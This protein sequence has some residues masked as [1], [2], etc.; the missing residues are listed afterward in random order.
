MEN[1]SLIS[2][3][4]PVYNVEAFLRQCVDS[5][6]A[7]TYKNLEI[8]LVDD[9]S[10]DQS[11]AICDEYAQRYPNIVAIHKKNGGLSS[12]RNT[13]I[14]AAKGAFLGFVDSDDFVE[15]TM[16]EKLLTA[17]AANDAS[18]ACCGR[19]V[20]DE[21]G[22]PLARRFTRK[23]Q[24]V[25]TML[26]AAQEILSLG[27]ID[28]AVWDKLFRAQLFDRIAFPI[29]EINEDAAIIFKLLVKAEKL[30]HV[31][32][33]LYYYRGRSGSI[34]K[35]GY[36][37]KKIQALEHAVSNEQFLMQDYPQLKKYCRQNL[38][39]TCCDLLSLM[40]KD[41]EA[42]KRYSEHYQWYLSG[43][44]HNAWYF[45]SNPNVS[46]AWKLRG[47]MVMLGLYEP[48]YALLKQEKK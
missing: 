19:Y 4:V 9:G 31:G 46:I 32:E 2:V 26:Q 41:A 13:G 40:L 16:F 6:L 42:K 39:Y 23:N 17:A 25:Y 3:I 21:Q 36:A 43:L 38:A 48:L 8:I 30:V 47:T 11:G 28:V 22:H 12:A 27:D 1:D 10:T 35:S 18:I 7:Q 33:P 20:T 34:T 5:I 24:K 44:R 29:G 15:A 14:A 45:Y 37:S